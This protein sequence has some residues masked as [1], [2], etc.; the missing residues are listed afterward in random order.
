MARLRHGLAFTLA[1]LLVAPAARADIESD[2]V[3]QG[4]AAYN[5]L[6]YHRAI[7]LLQ[8]A[9]QETLTREEKIDTFQT[10]AFAHVALDQSQA[11]IADFENLLRIDGTFELDRTISPR[12]RAVFDEART[13][14]ATG[15]GVQSG[16]L[17]LPTVTPSVTPTRVKEGEAVTISGTYPGGVAHG[18]ELLYRT[19]G[20]RIFATIKAPT[21]GGGRFAVNVPGLHVQAPA[22]EYYL[23]VVDEAGASL[24]FGGTLGQPLAVDIAGRGKKPL[25]A[26]GWFWGVLAGASVVVAG[27]VTAVTLTTSPSPSPSPSPSQSPWSGSR[28]RY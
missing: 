27:V 10:L 17:S 5:G 2:L 13:R 3:R 8:K 23:V 26:E 15:L 1:C 28:W 7:E 11:A 18:V 12:V 25:Y 19:R 6:L 9:M 20:Q 21:Y 14:V 4:I 16:P 24:A 22:L